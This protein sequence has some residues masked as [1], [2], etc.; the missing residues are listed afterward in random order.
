MPLVVRRIVVSAILLLQA[1][2]AW[3]GSPLMLWEASGKGSTV[4]LFG[5][6]HVCTA[7]CYPLSQSVL[8]R[9]DA[10]DA[11]IVELDAERSA[12]RQKL[13]EAGR[14]PAGKTLSG[15]LQASERKRLREVLESLDI[16]PE[17]FEGFRPWMV[18][19]MISVQAASKAGFESGFGIDLNLMKRS[20]EQGKKLI[21]LESAE[22]QMRAL[23]SGSDAEQIEALNRLVEQVASGKMPVML[24]DLLQAW[25]SGDAASLSG[26]IQDDMPEDSEQSK[27]LL[28]QRN[29]E[30]AGA[31][32]ARATRGGKYFVVI[33]AAHLVGSSGVPTLLARQGFRVVQLRDGE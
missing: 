25:K 12:S 16:P 22:R 18:A 27:Q 7:A 1:C 23:S 24:G 5:S 30:M 3:A 13:V 26:M 19:L 28:L 14:L 15:M 31:I 29:R 8:R 4:Y 17:A 2:L 20:R 6:I 11:L 9:F 32:A 21:E 33:G 10:S